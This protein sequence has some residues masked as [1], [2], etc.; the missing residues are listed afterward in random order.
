MKKSKPHSAEKG[1]SPH[2]R[3]KNIVASGSEKVYALCKPY[4]N[5]QKLIR[6]FASGDTH[7]REDY[8]CHFPNPQHACIM[9]FESGNG[10][11]TVADKS[12]EIGGGNLLLMREGYKWEYATDK[13]DPWVLHWLN[14]EDTLALQI[15]DYYHLPPVSVYTDQDLIFTL[16]RMQ[17]EIKDSTHSFT[18]KRDR[19]FQYLLH[20]V[21][22][23]SILLTDIK[24]NTPGAKDARTIADYITTHIME[25]LRVAD[26]ASLVFRSSFSASDVF[27][28][29][30]GCS[31]K[32]YILNT[33]C[34]VAARM[35]R[36]NN[37]S[38]SEIAEALSFCDAQHFSQIFKRRYNM[39][40]TDFRKKCLISQSH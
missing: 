13:N 2:G 4:I 33:K 14:L 28:A 38:V 27:K 8:F 7:C 34:E 24:D 9:Y 12:F 22:N 31:I 39:T 29:K 3:T 6:I 16:K 11:M 21:Q 15:L 18:E 10:R 1:V 32:E 35:L 40:P 25:N 17:E 26:L 19:T 37:C 36:E 23:F 5:G 20:L 30:Y